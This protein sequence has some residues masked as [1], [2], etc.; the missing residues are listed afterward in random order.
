MSFSEFSKDLGQSK[1]PS[2]SSST[3]ANA[4]T[5]TSFY[6]DIE[7]SDSSANSDSNENDPDDDDVAVPSITPSNPSSDLPD[8]VPIPGASSA[9]VA[10]S[11]S[12]SSS[13]SSSTAASASTITNISSVVSPRD[14]SPL[15]ANKSFAGIISSSPAPGSVGSSG[16]TFASSPTLSALSLGT[17][18]HQ[19]S[20]SSSSSK[21]FEFNG[22]QVPKIGKI[23]VCALDAKAR[24]KPCR[25]I[26]NKLIEHGEFETVI[27]GDK[28]ILDESIENWPTCDFLI[29]FFSNGFPLQ[30]AIDYVNLRKPYLV[31]DLELQKIL[32]DRRLV[33][34]LLEASGVPTPRRI[35][36][37]RDGGPHV[38][39]AVR[40]KLR[41]HGVEIKEEL[42][43]EFEMIDQD[44]LKFADGQILKKPF[45]EKPVDGEDH[46]VFVYYNSST[47]GGGRRLFRKVGNKSSEYDP[48][49]TSPRTEGSFIY[50]EF[51]DT[52]NFEDV[53]AYTVGPHF[54]HAETRKSPVVDGVVRRNTYGKEIRFV[55]KLTDE[56][57]KMASSISEAFEQTIC[58]FDLLRVNGKSYVIDVN[59]F[60][61]VKDNQDY[62]NNAARIL[63]Q[64]FIQAKKDRNERNKK[65]LPNDATVVEK[66]QK[67]KQKGQ[68]YVIRH[69]DRTPKQKFK[70]SFK[71]KTFIN[72]LRG[73]KEEVIIR[74]KPDLA[75]ILKV[76][77][78]AQ[79][80]GKEDPDKLSQLRMAL[81]KKKDFPG[82]KVQLKPVLNKEI[83]KV[84]KVQVI[85]KWGGEPTHSARYQAL[86]LGTQMR[87]ET[88]LLNKDLVNNVKIFTSSE[89][90]VVASARI[91]ASAY[92][93]LEDV[94][95]DLLSIRKDWLDDSNAAKDLM[96]KVKKKLK[97]LLRQGLE[98]PPQFTWPPK[99]PEPFIV[100]SRVV[101]LMNYHARILAYN[102]AH[103]D[104]DT[105]QSRWC[106]SEDPV[107]F[108]ERWDKLFKEFVSVEKVDP[109]KISEL[110]DT[111]K[112]DG[113]HNRQFLEHVF[114]PDPA[115]GDQFDPPKTA[116]APL[117]MPKVS[118]VFQHKPESGAPKASLPTSTA[119]DGPEFG[120]LRELYTLSKILFDFI[121][122]QEYGIEAKEKLDI[123]LLTSLPL[124]QQILKEIEEMQTGGEC[125]S[126]FYFTKESH[127]YTLLNVIYESQIPTKVARN[128]LPELDYLTQIG[129]EIYEAEDKKHSIRLTISP[130]CNTP[131]PLDVQLDSKHCISCI[132][133]V[134]LTRHLDS[135]LL[136]SK[137][138]S[139][140]ARVSLPKKFIPLNWNSGELQDVLTPPSSSGSSGGDD[141]ESKDI[142]ED[143]EEV[144]DIKEDKEEVKDI[145]EDKEE[146]KEESK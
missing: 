6:H 93:D 135:D 133:L 7:I 66:E 118:A 145:K 47:G 107:L 45:V 3:G 52:D 74:E 10:P 125:R 87:Q 76:T 139:R 8:P 26:L 81:E 2:S 117:Q 99:F 48:D 64:L 75:Y 46:N 60:S 106:C 38:E 141:E 122:P 134:A 70:F 126:V 89:R 119:F 43:L 105:F 30:K 33:L 44:T 101:E 67:W 84:E 143:K 129:F 39:P 50:E 62:Y 56:E 28:V 78:R 127:I 25:H 146:V 140:F 34:R 95:E 138:K 54:C 41:E 108:R 4:G 53:K 88:L 68:I 120:Y 61:F 18:S 131:N 121:C 79:D 24:S 22:T 55:T 137:F 132:P 23:G 32:W 17:D 31:N 29:S 86:D 9:D 104:V 114:R 12:T 63:R 128:H 144:K 115:M 5:P 136:A 124:V 82:T 113:L 16:P 40:E 142:K 19:R 1:P 69:A 109:S 58:G 49:L 42:P 36:V 123:G 21:T 96:D 77:K 27:F 91:W 100:L 85:I 51:M 20:V 13:I 94:P 57:I 35:V 14:L 98:P 11:S 15:P 111:M 97:P 102:F 110:Y 92:L 90:R 65:I 73:H 72:L 112:F 37:S 83:N 59:G 71:S 116:F 80:E 130:G 103:Q